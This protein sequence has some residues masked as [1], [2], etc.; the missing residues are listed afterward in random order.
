M[1]RV[2]I[3]VLEIPEPKAIP[4]YGIVYH[5]FSSLSTPCRRP[6]HIGLLRDSEVVR[7]YLDSLT[8]GHPAGD[9]T[10]RYSNLGCF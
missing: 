7:G 5:I 3:W 10:N 9:A 2:I 8:L 1:G 6:E 4:Y